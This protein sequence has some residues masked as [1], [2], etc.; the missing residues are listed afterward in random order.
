MRAATELRGNIGLDFIPNHNAK[1]QPPT[2]FPAVAICAQ[3]L[4][5]AP[6]E[7]FWFADEVPWLTEPWSAASAPTPDLDAVKPPAASAL[8]C[9][10]AAGRE[11]ADVLLVELVGSDAC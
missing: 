4:T 2:S 6:A 1:R 10:V 11:S 9:V 3:R 5:D 7:P 8:P